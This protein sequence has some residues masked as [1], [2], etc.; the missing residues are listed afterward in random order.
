MH[1]RG[2]GCPPSKQWEPLYQEAA[3]T[4]VTEAVTLVTEA[5][6]VTCFFLPS[7]PA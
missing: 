1:H 7:G 5:V 4:L 6:Q 3:V 2:Q